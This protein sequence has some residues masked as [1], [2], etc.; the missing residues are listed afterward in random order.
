MFSDGV[1]TL[2][3]FERG[4]LPTVLAWVNDFELCR[5]IDR[6]LPV[7][8]LE[9]EKWY[10]ALILRPDAV[11]FAIRQTRAR[12]AARDP[13]RARAA[14]RGQVRARPVARGPAGAGLLGLCG[15]KDMHRRHR[16]AELWIYIGDA[17][18]R[19]QGL[20]RRSVQL[21]ARYGFDQLNLHR[22][23]L[24]VPAYNEAAQR[25][26]QACGFHEEGRD[27]DAI[28]IDGQYQDVVRMGLL[29]GELSR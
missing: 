8:Q 22:I 10:E 11:T 9:H 6:V 29:R 20:G 15:L 3:P 21:L 28:Y 13:I 24:Y 26:Y 18:R 7:T 16:R 4:D 2:S 25:T 27:R 5:A 19:G 14:A 12:A 1:V 17:A 23:Y